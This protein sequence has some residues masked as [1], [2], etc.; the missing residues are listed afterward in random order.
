MI[1]SLD[2]RMIIRSK[3]RFYCKHSI[4]TFCCFFLSLRSKTV[5]F[6]V[7]VRKISRNHSQVKRL[8]IEMPMGNYLQDTCETLIRRIAEREQLSTMPGQLVLEFGDKRLRP[9]RTLASYGVQNGDLLFLLDPDQRLSFLAY[10]D[11]ANPSSSHP[12]LPM[13]A[14]P[15]TTGRARNPSSNSTASDIRTAT[16]NEM[17]YNRLNSSFTPMSSVYSDE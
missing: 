4:D 16:S 2:D 12:T 11:E 10:D 7:A 14:P 13:R 5:L 9:Q 3:R 17:I 6:Y 8:T 1:A 15:S